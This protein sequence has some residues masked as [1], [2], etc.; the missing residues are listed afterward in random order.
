MEYKVCPKCKR[1]LSLSN[2]SKDKYK[3][4]GYKS[5]CKE[6]LSE[7]YYEDKINNNEKYLNYARVYRNRHPEKIKNY[8]KNNKEKLSQKHKE[9]YIENKEKIRKQYYIYYHK[10]GGKDVIKLN[11]IKNKNYIAER[12][13]KRRHTEE[14]RTKDRL[15][16]KMYRNTDKGKV[17]LLNRDHRRRVNINNTPKEILISN[18]DLLRIK[19]VYTH[20]PYCGIEMTEDLRYKGTSNYKTLEHIIPINKGGSHTVENV[21]FCCLRCNCSK[22]D[23]LLDEW[24]NLKDKK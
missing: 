8:Y 19:N 9:Y 7:F 24:R 18:Y 10:R 14:F 2:F 11:Y 1:E 4:N 21:I 23:K 20:C 6:C 15:Y 17:V 3:S 16:H 5:R 12:E 13:K 22:Q